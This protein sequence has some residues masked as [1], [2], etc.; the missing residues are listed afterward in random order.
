[1]LI[2]VYPWAPTLADLTVILLQLLGFLGNNNG[3]TSM[4]KESRMA[5]ALQAWCDSAASDGN[6]QELGE[7]ER[8]MAKV[9]VHLFICFLKSH[10]LPKMTENEENSWTGKASHSKLLF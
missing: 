8:N 9:N 10:W 1:M 5:G 2:L 4:E 6:H 3:N 7:R